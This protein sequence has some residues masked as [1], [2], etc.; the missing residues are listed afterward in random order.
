MSGKDAEL[1]LDPDLDA[2]ESASGAPRPIHLRPGALMLVFVGGTLGTAA[3]EALSLAFPPI[4]GIP[5]AILG[6]NI[7]GALLL[8]VLLESLVRRGP[9][10]GGRQRLRLLLGTGMLGG[11][12]TY[13]ALAVDTAH[14]VG[15]GSA[16]MGAAYGIGTVLLGAVATW[17]G[18]ALASAAH[19]RGQR[20]ITGRA[21]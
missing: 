7:T 3:R 14:L 17:V 2:A 18:I 16:G 20:T 10:R 1:P 4:D 5:Y 19:G 12:T 6:I 21:R 13:S 15:S 9:D 11:F 8:G